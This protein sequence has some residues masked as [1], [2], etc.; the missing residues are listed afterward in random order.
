[1]AR[2]VIRDQIQIALTVASFLIGQTV[3]LIWQRTQCFGQQTQFATMDRQL[4]GFGFKQLT[5]CTQNIAQIP[6]F[7][8]FVINAFREVITGNVQLNTTTDI[9]QRDE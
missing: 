9:L 7:E 5:A 8:F 1:M 6:L 2:F 3:E 4:T